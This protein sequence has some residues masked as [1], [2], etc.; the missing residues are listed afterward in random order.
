M[1]SD[2]VVRSGGTSHY[3]LTGAI[4][5]YTSRTAM[6][7]GDV[8]ATVHDIERNRKGGPRLAAGRPATAQSC[9]HFARAMTDRA[10]FAGWIAPEILFVGPRTIAWWRAP[11][12]AT[13][14]F[15]T[16][17]DKNAKRHIGNRTGRLPQPGLVHMLV[18]G[19]WHVYAVKGA[20]RPKP[21][22]QIFHSPHFNVH[23]DGEI[24]EGN[25]R[26]P[27]RVTPET[28]A[29]FERAFFQTRFTH[30]NAD[31][32]VLTRYRHG[33]HALWRDLLDRKLKSFPEASL[34]PQG[35][36]TLESLLR[37]FEGKKN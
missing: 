28:L 17:D 32:K 16:I 26:R 18:E 35:K 10:A 33:V 36:H 9:E 31:S 5:L 34:A 11:A 20:A 8:Y 25:V 24:C 2:V 12:V 3:E 15:E 13:M 7:V 1:T 30:P 6:G 4:L 29:E 19:K 23:A 22:T 27:E 37:S 21:A 14:F